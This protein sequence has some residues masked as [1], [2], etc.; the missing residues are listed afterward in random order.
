MIEF[1]WW[2]VVLAYLF[3]FM[4]YFGTGALLG[5]ILT[6]ALLSGSKRE[7]K[8]RTKARRIS[9]SFLGALGGG[10][11]NHVIALATLSGP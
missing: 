4:A 10:V 2:F 3:V 1:P 5:F 8:H 11:V 9:L 6:Y 7:G